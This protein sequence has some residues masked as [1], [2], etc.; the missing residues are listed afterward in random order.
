M[1]ESKRDNGRNVE[2]MKAEAVFYL[3]NQEQNL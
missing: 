2:Q 1:R 3:E